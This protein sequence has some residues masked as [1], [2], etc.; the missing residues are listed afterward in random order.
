LETAYL[1]KNGW[2]SPD[3]GRP[4]KFGLKPPPPRW[5]LVYARCDEFRL[6][7]H[8]FDLMGRPNKS[9]MFLVF[10]VSETF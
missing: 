8:P 6:D 1:R 5:S 2:G 9:C 10:P 7:A 4:K 3:Y